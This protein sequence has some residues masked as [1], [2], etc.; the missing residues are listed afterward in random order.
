MIVPTAYSFPGHTFGT[1]LITWQQRAVVGGSRGGG[2]LG[3]PPPPFL[4]IPQLHKEGKKCATY[5]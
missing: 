4:G 3:V 2:V 5:W 1:C